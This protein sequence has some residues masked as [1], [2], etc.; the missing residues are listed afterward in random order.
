MSYCRIGNTAIPDFSIF[1]TQNERRIS[2]K[3]KNPKKK[4][5]KKDGEDN[6]N[7]IQQKGLPENA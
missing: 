3:V 4:G 6:H 5:D 7:R 2:V 1:S